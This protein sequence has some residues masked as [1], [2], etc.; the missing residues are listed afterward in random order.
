MGIKEK[1]SISND[2]WGIVKKHFMKSV[3][4]SVLTMG[5]L[6]FLVWF[7]NRDFLWLYVI[8]IP[9]GITTIYTFLNLKSFLVF[10]RKMH[11]IISLYLMLGMSLFSVTAGICAYRNYDYIGLILFGIIMGIGIV[12]LYREYDSFFQ[13][14][15]DRE[16]NKNVLIG[17][18]REHDYRQYNLV[19][20]LKMREHKKIVE[21]LN[22][23]LIIV[24]NLMFP[25]LIGVT[26]LFYNKEG[27]L[28]YIDF[29]LI[30][31]SFIAFGLVKHL[32][33]SFLIYRKIRY[34][35]KESSRKII[36]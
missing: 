33:K 26:K 3:G 20:D 18:K 19:K 2:V 16:K 7:V 12:L 1:Y 9:W 14:I 30:L 24:L 17:A 29:I 11:L 36:N 5:L 34:Y 15:W 8:V 28:L 22:F 32:S 4:K 31:C 27:T 21:M 6:S 35:E 13:N 23:K 10:P 25:V